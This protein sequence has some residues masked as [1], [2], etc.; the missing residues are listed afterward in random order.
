M[1]CQAVQGITVNLAGVAGGV[2]IA[3]TLL[4][5]ATLTGCQASAPPTEPPTT[6]PTTESSVLSTPDREIG[7]SKA[8]VFEV[9]APEATANNQ[10]DPGEVPLIPR[11]YPGA[12]P[13]VPHN[14]TDMVPITQG[15]NLCLDCHAISVEDAEP[16]DPTPIPVSH[17]ID[18][19]GGGVARD[20][21]VGARWV[22]V[23]CHVATTDAEPLVDNLLR[24]AVP[25]AGR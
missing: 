15:D 14:V 7:L 17:N 10:A 3:A 20:E 25:G 8:S 2:R 9:P 23:S 6:R 16:G 21:A 24:T 1:R 11:A 13:Q 18:I 22:C 12:P 5:V 19:R 4:L